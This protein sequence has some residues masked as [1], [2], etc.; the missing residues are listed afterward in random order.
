MTEQLSEMVV[1]GDVGSHGDGR[2]STASPSGTNNGKIDDT[3]I[4]ST[5]LTETPW[6]GIARC[7]KASGPGDRRPTGQPSA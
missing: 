1:P 4:F 5:D 2:D 6:P 3:G 7:R